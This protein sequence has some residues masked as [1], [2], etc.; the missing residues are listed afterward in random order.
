MEKLKRYFTFVCKFSFLFLLF[1]ISLFARDPFSA[2]RAKRAPRPSRRVAGIL[3]VDGV[4]S[5]LVSVGGKTKIVRQGDQVGQYKVVKIGH[6]TVVTMR[7]NSEEE[8]W[9]IDTR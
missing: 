4:R 8:T 6:R 5:A 9:S 1:F 7:K 2:P 3:E